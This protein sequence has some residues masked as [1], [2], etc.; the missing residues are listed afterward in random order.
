MGAQ[1]SILFNCWNTAS[2][3]SEGEM[4]EGWNFNNIQLLKIG[5]FQYFLKGVQLKCKSA[6]ALPLTRVLQQAAVL[7]SILASQMK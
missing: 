2:Q 6:C 3:S 4:E 5:D 1:N 7:Q